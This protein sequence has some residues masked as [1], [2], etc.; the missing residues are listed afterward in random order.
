MK[1]KG[2]FSTGG[3]LLALTCSRGYAQDPVARP[4]MPNLT[5]PSPA[6]STED[7][8]NGPT[9]AK[10]AGSHRLFHVAFGP[11]HK[12]QSCPDAQPDCKP[13]EAKPPEAKPPEAAPPNLAQPPVTDFTPLPAAGTAGATTYAPNMIGDQHG[14]GCGQVTFQSPNGGPAIFGGSIE[15][16]TFGCSRQNIAEDNSPIPRDRVYVNYNHFQGESETA[17]FGFENALNIERYTFGFEKTFLNGLASVE[18]RIPFSHELSS[19]LLVEQVNP[20]FTPNPT[21]NNLPIDQTAT[22]FGNMDLIAKLLLYQ[23]P[24]LAVSTGLGINLPTAP[25][26]HVHVLL[27]DNAFPIAGIGPTPVYANVNGTVHN[28]WVN[29]SPYIAG[30]WTPTDRF[31]AQSF[32][33]FDIPPNGSTA[34]LDVAANVTSGNAFNPALIKT[35]PTQEAKLF[36]QPLMRVSIGGGYWFVRRPEATWLTGLAGQIEMHYVTALEN[37]RLVSTQLLNSTL[38]P[39]PPGTPS[40][41]FVI[42]NL[43]NRVDIFN[44]TLGTTIELGNRATITPAFVIPLSSGDN[45]AFDWEFQLQLNWRFGPQDRATRAQF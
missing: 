18:L 21:A 36:E 27:Q 8:G 15:H 23:S 30:L 39:L 5:Q 16:P 40:P 9:D 33:Q 42:G 37:A 2:L 11:F 14:G 28:E 4:A 43:A 44:L 22:E 24:K 20:S 6:T 31:F 12:A 35:Q 38:F 41:N 45:K 7:Q 34:S 1:M 10:D 13:P 32:V 19:N 29:L 3:M 25:D 26:V 17:V